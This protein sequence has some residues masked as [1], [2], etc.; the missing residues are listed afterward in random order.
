[1]AE[2]HD[3]LDIQCCY[4][5][6]SFSTDQRRSVHAKMYHPKRQSTKA[7]RHI[8]KECDL[9]MNIKEAVD[10]MEIEHN[11]PNECPFCSFEVGKVISFLA[12]IIIAIELCQLEQ[13]L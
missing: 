10:H 12:L 1:M 9:F 13:L 3:V 4:C 8:C 6:K 2:V 11:K 7:R 5:L